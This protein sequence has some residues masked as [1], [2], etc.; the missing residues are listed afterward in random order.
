MEEITG[1]TPT[2]LFAVYKEVGPTSHD[3]MYRIKRL[4]PGEKVGHAG[5]L[6]PL[7]SGILVVGVGRQATKQLHTEH[8]NDKEYIAEVTLG[9]SSST[10][11][12]E[13]EKENWPV[14]EHPSEQNVRAA[15]KRFIGRISQ[16]PPVF[17]AVKRAGVPAYKLARRGQEVLLTA[18]PAEI[19]EIEVLSY[20]WPKLKIRVVTGRGVYI[21]SLARDIGV[22]LGVGGHISQLERIRVGRYGLDDVVKIEDLKR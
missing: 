20:D 18:R 1:N 13:G 10:D 21:R 11:D 2:K 15:I 5:T 17:S 16:V 4:F 14:T 22:A 12:A 3:M 8:L 9:Q 7:A 19:M 6:D